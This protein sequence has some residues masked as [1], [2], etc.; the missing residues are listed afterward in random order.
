M[1]GEYSVQVWL[2]GRNLY[3][4]KG[5]VTGQETGEV[6]ECEK[7]GEQAMKILGAGGIKPL[8]RARFGK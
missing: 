2:S 7:L 5:I 1:C 3:V 6:L 8:M 4:G